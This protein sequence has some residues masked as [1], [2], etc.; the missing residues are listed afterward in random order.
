[1]FLWKRYWANLVY[2]NLHFAY[3]MSGIKWV[4]SDLKLVR[5]Q[6][7]TKDGH[8]FVIYFLLLKLVPTDRVNIHI[9]NQKYFITLKYR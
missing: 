8:L 4:R 9:M 1:M 2:P 5:R 7:Q 6:G 3:K